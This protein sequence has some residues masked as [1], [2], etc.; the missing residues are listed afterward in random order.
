M[1]T[2]RML[3]DDVLCLLEAIIIKKTCVIEA[4]YAG[5]VN[6]WKNECQNLCAKF[7]SEGKEMCG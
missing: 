1:M 5:V 7:L 6:K 3:P 2:I 4:Y